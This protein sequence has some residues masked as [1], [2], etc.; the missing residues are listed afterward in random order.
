MSWVKDVFIGAGHVNLGVIRGAK[1]WDSPMIKKAVCSVLSRKGS[2]IQFV[3]FVDI[4]QIAATDGEQSSNHPLARSI[5]DTAKQARIEP[6][7]V[8]RTEE[9]HGRGVVAHTTD[10]GSIY[11]GRAGWLREVNPDISDALTEVE[12]KI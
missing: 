6:R 9:V 7:P 10:G 8:E 12:S 2:N 11:A 4:R 3:R 5:L 1:K